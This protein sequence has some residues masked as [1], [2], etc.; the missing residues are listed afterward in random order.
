MTSAGATRRASL[1]LALLALAGCGASPPQAPLAEAKKLDNA[2]GGI[3]TACGEATQVTAFPGN[4][5]RDLETLEATAQTAALKLASVYRGNP[6]WVYQGETVGKI[7]TDSLSALH[8]CGLPRAAAT[9]AA[10]TRGRG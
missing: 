4:H 5:A 2:T 6:S 8:D 9:L 3:S 10:L 7:V 1:C